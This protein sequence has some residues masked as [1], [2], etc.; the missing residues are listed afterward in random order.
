MLSYALAIAVAISSLVLFSTAFLMSKIH[1]KDDFLWS[2]VGLFYALVLW[3]CARN[4]TGAVLLGQ[5]AA[6][7][8][9][10][11]SSWQTIKLRRAIASPAQA[12][13]TKSFSV[14]QSINGLLKRKKPQV[15]PPTPPVA[16]APTPKVTD[17]NIA[18]PETPVNI[19]EEGS[20]KVQDADISIINEA[21][22]ANDQ[23]VVEAAEKTTS[24][25]K[26]APN[27]Q[28]SPVET[29]LPLPNKLPESK[30]AENESATKD[31]PRRQPTEIQPDVQTE[32]LSKIANEKKDT[33]IT[34]EVEPTPEVTPPATAKST[35]PKSALDSLETVEVAEVLEA[36]SERQSNNRDTDRFNIIEVTTTE[37]N[38]TTE[39]I[40]T[41]H[42][43]DS[44]SDSEKV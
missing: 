34:Q 14:L 22:V 13:E 43:Q 6:T 10:V 8:L 42:N 15:E 44:D 1:R 26:N 21:N 20:K 28:A 33:A 17:Q 40:K 2:A 4:I 9:I 3:Y 23:P 39:V 12:V 11:S 38:V 31:T 29:E 30:P 5:A 24:A 25:I 32:D 36:E 27:S 7:V 35:K 16:K 37:I 18:I 41:D 19:A